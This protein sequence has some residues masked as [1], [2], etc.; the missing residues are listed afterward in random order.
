MKRY[1]IVY[2]I[3]FY[4]RVIWE[5]YMWLSDRGQV[6]DLR[7]KHLVKFQILINCITRKL[8]TCHCCRGMCKVP[9]WLNR[10]NIKLVELKF[11]H[12][13]NHGIFIFGETLHRITR[14]SVLACQFH[15]DNECRFQFRFVA[16][17]PWFSRIVN[18]GRA[19]PLRFHTK[20]LNNCAGN[21]K[22]LCS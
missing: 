8:F 2:V 4:M 16:F 6:V 20:C 9:L 12:F 17:G 14:D 3:T 1:I 13:I 22:L 11:N 18:L 19:P 15:V 5:I 7:A 21:S 10:H